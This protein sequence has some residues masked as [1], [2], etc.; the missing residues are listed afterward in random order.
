[1]TDERR[2]AAHSDRYGRP[3]WLERVGTRLGRL[4]GDGPL[5]RVVRRW[6][7]RALG[8]VTGGG[9]RSVLPHGEVVRIAPAFRF[10]TWNPVEY[11]A[12]RSVLRP[13]DAALDVGANV[14]AYAILFGQWTG[15]GGRVLAFEPAPAAFEG[16]RQHIALNGLEACVRP[17]QVAVSDAIGEAEFVSDGV[18]GTNHLG[19]GA[20]SN[21]SV[22]IRVPTTTID[23]I[24]GR[25]GLHPRL[26][27]IDVEGAELAVLRGA[28]ATIAAM[29]RD[30]GIFVEMHPAAWRTMGLSV[31]DMLAELA[32]QGLRA[33]PLRE[34]SDPW[35]LDGECMRLVRD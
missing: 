28:R 6:Y 11:D 13:G 20:E 3:P 26:I 25:E 23:E 2:A 29:G 31:D 14:G 12:F 24:C 16:L 8:L 1:M 9:P 15:E 35:A 5:R 30:A 33:V 32:T 27:K 10:M 19:N 7:R 21:A 18:Q 34:V 4:I 17:V 22:V